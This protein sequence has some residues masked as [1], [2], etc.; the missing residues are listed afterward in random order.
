[1]HL[2]HFP[3][4]IAGIAAAKYELVAAL[5]ADGVAVLNADDE[6]VS[7]F[8]RGMG[9]RAVF[10]GME[11]GAAVRATGVMEVGAEGVVFSVEAK[12]ESGGERASGH[13][14]GRHNVYNALAAIAVGL[15][16]GIPLAECCWAVGGLT[17]GD[18]R[19]EV[20]SWRGA[21]LINDCYNSNPRA[22]DAM[23][24]ALLAMPAERHIVIA[25][26]MLELGPEAAAL[27]AACGLRMAQRGVDVV[28]GVR[29]MAAS[30]VE[31]A[32]ADAVFCAT[33]EEAGAWMVEH[34]RA[35]DVVLLKGSRG[36]RLE[37]ALTVLN[38]D[39][40]VT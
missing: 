9:E 26:E 29:G 23:V 1:M 30:L 11:E 37:R 39:G 27:H 21:T 22:L 31:A 32:G 5:P 25:G 17:A 12:S 19:G 6:W 7:G 4:G 24:D 36:V 28:V 35:G 14:L 18:K 34:V 20:V 16:S 8:G 10:F 13:L 38:G 15:R 33:P 2:E 40:A 3:E